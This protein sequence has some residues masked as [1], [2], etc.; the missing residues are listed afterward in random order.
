MENKKLEPYIELL[1]AIIRQAKTDY[2]D[3][4]RNPIKYNK[5]GKVTLKFKAYVSARQ[6]LFE[7]KS[8][9]NFFHRFHLPD[10]S[11]FIRNRIR[12]LEKEI[13]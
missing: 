11:Q 6:F 8:L 9:E 7:R 13:K 4:K 1:G 12:E 10:N 5:K 3:F 2:L